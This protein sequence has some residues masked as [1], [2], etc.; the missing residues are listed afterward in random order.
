MKSHN[1][2]NFLPLCAKNTTA[3]GT[4]V[5]EKIARVFNV[6]ARGVRVSD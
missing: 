1:V 5:P 2:H 4:S 3:A 6:T